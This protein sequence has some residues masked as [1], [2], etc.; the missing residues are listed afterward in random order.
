[1]CIVLNPHC[2]AEQKAAWLRQLKKWNGVDVC[3]WED[4]NHSNELPNLTNALPQGAHGNQGE[5]E[6]VRVWGGGAL[7]IN[8][9]TL[10]PLSSPF[11]GLCATNG[12]DLMTPPLSTLLLYGFRPCFANH[13]CGQSWKKGLYWKYLI[14]W[15]FYMRWNVC[16]ESFY[17]IFCYKYSVLLHGNYW[18]TTSQRLF[19]S[20]A[21][22]LSQRG[23]DTVEWFYR[24]MLFCLGCFVHTLWLVWPK[25]TFGGLN[26]YHKLSKHPQK[27]SS[28]TENGDK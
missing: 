13:N 4:G 22:L 23:I 18:E 28:R 19:F 7:L 17:W 11:I 24:A 12:M 8:C 2:K 10:Q 27:P 1:M 20:F 5:S 14:S 6:C 15:H 9:A 25:L 3:P 26:E 16:E 21:W